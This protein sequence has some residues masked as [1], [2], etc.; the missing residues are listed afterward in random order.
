MII[1]L[2][3][4][5][6]VALSA[7]FVENVVFVKLLG[8]GHTFGEIKRIKTSISIGVSV[9]LVMVLSSIIVFVANKFLLIRFNLTYLRILIFV[10]IIVLT[11]KIIEIF[12]LKLLSNI[13]IAFKSYIPYIITNCAVLGIAIIT[14]DRTQSFL[15]TIV[16][17]F[18]AA[19]GFTLALVLIS[20]VSEKLQFCDVPEAFKGAPILFIAVALLAMAFMGFSGMKFPI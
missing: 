14:I 17:S 12:L 15:E 7:I 11:I 9:A 5:F 1:M 13:H 4:L 19:V 20:S 2:A 10:L 3:K 6:V 18:F 16:Y 8:D